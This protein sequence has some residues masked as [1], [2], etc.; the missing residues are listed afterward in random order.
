MT[1][2]LLIG[3]GKGLFL[4]HSEDGRKS[5]DVLATLRPSTRRKVRRGLRGLGAVET[6]WAESPAHA[7]DIL[8]ELIAL[9][10]ARW[11]RADL[12][13]AF[14]SARFAGFHRDLHNSARLGSTVIIKKRV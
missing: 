10:Q 11:R 6:E 3:T 13:G 12:P 2:L 9:H 7:L 4:A 1:A 5:W 8:E 14:A